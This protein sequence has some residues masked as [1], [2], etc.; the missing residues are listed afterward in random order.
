[1]VGRALSKF[2]ASPWCLFFSWPN[3]RRRSPSDFLLISNTSS[4]T[5]KQIA[6]A[7]DKKNRRKTILGK[8]GIFGH[9]FFL[10]RCVLPMI[11]I[12]KH[13]INE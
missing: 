3:N 5:L 10:Q 7:I 6:I 9:S 2:L 8:L 1:V 13:G 12:I 4:I 11:K